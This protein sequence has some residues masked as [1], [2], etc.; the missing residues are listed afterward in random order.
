[1]VTPPPPIKSH[2]LPFLKVPPPPPATRNLTCSQTRLFQNPFD[3][4]P[5]IG[6]GGRGRAHFATSIGQ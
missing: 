6:N 4:P 2:L 1:M 3:S 5:P